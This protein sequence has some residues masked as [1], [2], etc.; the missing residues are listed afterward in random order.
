MINLLLSLLLTAVPPIHDYHVSKTN[1]R[2]AQDRQEW[3]VE[4]HLFVDDLERDMVAAGAPQPLEIGTKLEHADA[5]GL[6]DN[7]LANHFVLTADGRP[8]P[9][10]TVGYELADDLH[11]IWIYLRADQNELPADLAVTNDLL[12][13]TYED[14]KNIVK[15]YSGNDRLG[16]LLFSKERTSGKLTLSD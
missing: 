9:L 11:G 15:V 5:A 7:Y 4:M 6:L 14:Q 10:E 2:Y 3:Q 8:V 16:T 12:T 13:A 1:L